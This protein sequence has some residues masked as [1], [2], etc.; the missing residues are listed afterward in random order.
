MSKWD[1]RFLGMAN[2]VGSWSKDPSTQVGACIVDERNRIISVGYN[3]FARGVNDL[4]HHLDNRDEKLRR[5]IHAEQN[6]LAFAQRDLTGCTIYITHPPCARCAA[7]IIQSGIKR[8]VSHFP[9]A[10]FV[11]RWAEDMDSTESQFDEAGIVYELVD[12]HAQA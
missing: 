1:M 3:G 5:T 12:P 9:A 7:L 4:Q 10:D 2:L 11:T 8:V 6:A